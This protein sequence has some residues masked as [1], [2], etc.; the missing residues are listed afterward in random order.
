MSSPTVIVVT[1]IIGLLAILLVFVGRSY[2]GSSSQLKSANPSFV[3]TGPANAGSTSLFSYLTS[4]RVPI[5][6]ATSQVGNEERDFKLPMEVDTPYVFDLIE[7]PGQLKV[8]YEAMSYLKQHRK[9]IRGLV[10]VVD[11]ASGAKGIALAAEYLLDILTETEKQAGGVDILVA[12]NKSDVFNAISSKRL[13]EAMEA[14]IDRLRKS[15]SKGLLAS[16]HDDTQDDEGANW[17]GEDIGEF[18][19]DQLEGLVVFADGS[20][21]SE[22]IEKWRIWLDERAVNG[23]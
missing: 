11:A 16:H 23:L 18:K 19:F 2:L 6:T 22:N 7:F 21:K 15:R 4:G 12:A 13:K 3:I 14:E 17:I 10:Y 8:R 9:N 5:D 1:A 20:I